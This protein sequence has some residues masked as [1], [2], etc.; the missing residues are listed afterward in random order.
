MLASERLAAAMTGWR[1]ELLCTATSQPK[2]ILANALLALRKASE[3][4]GVLA[5]DEFALIPMALNPPPWC[6]NRDNDWKPMRWS[7][8]D[9]ALTAEWLQRRDICVN[10][11][12]AAV[13][14]AT[15]ASGASYHPVRDYLNGLVWDGID[16]VAQFASGYLGAE[17]TAYHRAVSRCTLIAAVARIMVPGCKVDTMP[18]FEGRQDAGK[19]TACSLMFSPWFSDDT[20]ELGS[21]DAAMQ[22]RVAWGIEVAELAAM[23]RGEVE[24]TKAFISRNTDIFRPSYGRHVIHAPRQSVFWGTTNSEDYLKDETGG[25]R[26]WPIKCGHI[27]LKAIERHRD[28]LWAEAMKLYQDGVPWWLTDKEDVVAAKEEQAERYVDDAWS[29]AIAAY[30]ESKD[31]V[32]VDEI[33]AKVLELEIARRDQ[34]AKNRVVAC[35]RTLGLVRYRGPRPRQEKRYR[36]PPVN[37]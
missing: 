10:E 15:V 21:K 20:A 23:R 7:D 36:R 13:A 11:R 30:V 3:W 12:V 22:V 8:H 34:L 19:S 5:Y 6:K 35:L 24:K 25:R 37:G 4:E 32:T 16:R 17:D 26:F 33:L 1:K 28:Q 18:I 9:D 27:D 2:P 14:V 29:D 31:Y